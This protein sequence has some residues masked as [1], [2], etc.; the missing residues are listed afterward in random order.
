MGAGRA[1][2]KPRLAR[3][4]DV[5]GKPIVKDGKVIS[6]FAAAGTKKGVAKAAAGMRAGG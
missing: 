3:A 5:D 4:L 6:I 2:F 1:T